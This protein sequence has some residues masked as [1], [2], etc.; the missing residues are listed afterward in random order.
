[1]VVAD[2]GILQNNINGNHDCVGRGEMVMDRIILR[3]L[4]VTMIYEGRDLTSS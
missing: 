1:M 4:L 2:V 3:K